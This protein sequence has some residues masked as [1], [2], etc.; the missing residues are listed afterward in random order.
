MVGV[1]PWVERDRS[2]KY[3]Q[4]MLKTVSRCSESSPRLFFTPKSS[5][6]NV[7]MIGPVSYRSS[8]LQA[9]RVGILAV[10]IMIIQ[11]CNEPLQERLGLLPV[12]GHIDSFLCLSHHEADLD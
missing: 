8:K 10:T 7:N 11:V 9:W 3:K 6:S 2:S 4:Q 5:T 12:V 1:I